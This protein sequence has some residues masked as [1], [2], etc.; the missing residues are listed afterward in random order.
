MAAM[1]AEQDAVA[2]AALRGH[3]HSLGPSAVDAEVRSLCLGPEDDDGLALLAALLAYFDAALRGSGGSSDADARGR[4]TADGER[5]AGPAAGYELVQAQLAL[6]LQVYGDVIAAS[7]QLQAA[8][9]RLALA[10]G[11]DATRVRA[12]LDRGLCMIATF[13]GQA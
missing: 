12:M 2:V 5:V 3:L 10:H 9:A 8:A 1:S 13:L 11:R 4:E 6:T 7:S